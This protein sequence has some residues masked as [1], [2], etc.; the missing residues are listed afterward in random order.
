MSKDYNERRKN[1]EEYATIM[2]HLF[3]VRGNGLKTRYNSKELKRVGK[4]NKLEG[5][6]E[7]TKRFT[8]QTGIYV[9]IPSIAKSDYDTKYL[10]RIFN[11]SNYDGQN[12][13]VEDFDD[14]EEEDDEDEEEEEEEEDENDEEDEADED[15][16][17]YDDDDE[18][19]EEEEEEE[20]VKSNK[21]RKK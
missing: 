3:K 4:S 13:N 10:L 9:I 11:Q 14:D 21:Q 17:D 5:E 18:E 2:F 1:D 16:S 7:V 8:L 15:E 19:E 12:D 6:R 20:P